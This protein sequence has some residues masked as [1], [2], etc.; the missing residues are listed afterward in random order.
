LS[1]KLCRISSFDWIGLPISRFETN[2]WILNVNFFNSVDE[3]NQRPVSQNTS[4]SE[5]N[6]VK[7]ISILKLFSKNQKSKSWIWLSYE[8]ADWLTVEL[9]S[10][11]GGRIQQTSIIK[12]WR[13]PKR[14]SSINQHSNKLS[15][16]I[17]NLIKVEHLYFASG[18]Y[19]MIRGQI[20]II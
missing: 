3:E 11:L 4:S 5:N 2:V 9:K 13:F 12:V 1:I 8:Y 7:N 20:Q 10:S 6:W 16:R 19:E 17:C 15:T 18:I 14:S